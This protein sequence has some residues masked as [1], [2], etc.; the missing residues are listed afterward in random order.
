MSEKDNLYGI[1]LI[2]GSVFFLVA[3]LDLLQHTPFST[4]F[5][6][7]IAYIMVAIGAYLIAK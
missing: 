2:A 1:I 5:S 7:L 4:S 3:G 6:C